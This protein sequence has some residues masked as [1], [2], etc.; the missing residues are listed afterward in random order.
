M[1]WPGWVAR[2]LRLLTG[3]ARIEREMDEEMRFHLEMEADALRQERGLSRDEARRAAVLGFGGMERFK[4]EGRDARGGRWLEDARH[5]LRY[6]ARTLWA[7]PG[8]TATAVMT[9]ALGI[10]ATTAIFS[11]VDGVLL[12]PLPYPDAHELVTVWTTNGAPD[13]EPFTSSPPDFRELEQLSRSFTGLAAYTVA[14]VNLSST[15][16]PSRL[17]AARV[18]PALF[19]IL[20]VLPRLGRPFDRHEGEFGAHRVALLSDGLWRASFGADPAAIGRTVRIDRQPYTI[21]GVMPRSFHFPDRRTQLWIPLAFAPDDGSNTRG[22]YFLQ[23]VGRLGAGST[24]SQAR[25]EVESIASTIE[26]RFPG[27][28]MK[29]AHVGTLREDVIGNVQGVLWVLLAAVALL[30]LIACANLANLM[31]ARGASRGREIALRVCLGASR[32]RLVRQLL[33]ES[34]TIAILGALVGV[35]LATAGVAALERLGPSDLP[36][37]D[38]VRVDLRSLGVA[39]GLC[40]LTSVLF[41]LLP[42]LQVSRSQD[43]EVLREGARASAGTG[44]RRIRE[45]LVAIEMALAVLLLVGA[46]LLLRSFSEVL[47]TDPGFRVDR[48]VTMSIALPE[49]EYPD[50]P[51]MWRFYDPLLERVRALPGVRSAAATSALSLR[52]GYWG[53]QIS[54]AARP[55]ATAMEQVEDLGYRVVSRDYFRTMGVRLRRGRDFTAADHAGSPGVAVINEAAA[56]H[57]WPDGDPI[58]TTIWLGPP[59]A[60]LGERL[61]PD[62]RF[63]RLEVVGIVEDERFAGLDQPAVPEVYQ[64]YDHVTETPSVMYLG[65]LVDA[66]AEQIVAGVRAAVRE[67]DPHETV[68]EVAPM[69]A[70]VHLATSQRRF[71]LLLIGTFASLAILL[72]AVGLYGVVA[73][74]VTQRR[75]EF[76]IRLALGATKSSVLRLVVKE[77]VRPAVIGAAIGL[78][79]ATFATHALASMLFGVPPV[80]PATYAAVATLL[81]AVATVGSAIPAWGALRA[82]PME[83]LRTD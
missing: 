28:V 53:K 22:N 45:A 42:A 3:P 65:L 44:R 36:R 1:S 10:G 18:S 49:T 25:A 12:K 2:R 8:F 73:Y 7:T 71:A 64:L 16:E 77:G 70:L 61:P 62:F 78:V 35:L 15:G 33:T 58:G 55:P 38:E 74:G 32:S 14:D 46:G 43:D 24:L 75:R 5:D 41:G 30:L 63:P 83:A 23:I 80:D 68:A 81:L 52:G 26:A 72:A 27:A 56:R 6:T 54:L 37:L 51:S 69:R 76:G 57:F 40:L 66:D 48:L 19:P 47:R 39:T 82:S 34:L 9:L 67:L 31:L 21:V 13:S 59:E 50:G 60:L 4:E 29:G 11:V 17:T 79:A 20:G